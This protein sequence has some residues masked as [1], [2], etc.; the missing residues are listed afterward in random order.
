MTADGAEYS[1]YAVLLS[2]GSTY[3]RLGIPGEEDFIGA[4]VHF[5]AT[6]DGAF[7]RD[8]EVMVIGGGNSAGEEGLFLTRFASHV[9]IATR[10][11]MLTASKVVVE[12]VLE[13]PKVDVLTDIVAVEFK[14]GSHLETVVCESTSGGQRRELHPAGVFVFIGLSPNT[15]IVQGVVDLDPA[16]FVLTGAGMQTSV[17]GV[18]AAGDCRSSSTKQAASAAGEGAAAAIAIRR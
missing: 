5:C 8:R 4:G 14:G 10:D 1:T 12:K 13:N 11:P 16:G 15:D 7:Y 18:F 3:R 2:L 6:C 9:T 17:P